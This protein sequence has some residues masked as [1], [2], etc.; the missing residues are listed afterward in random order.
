[1]SKRMKNV[2]ILNQLLKSELIDC[3][4]LKQT[5]RY[6]LVNKF[7]VF[8]LS[9]HWIL[10]LIHTCYILKKEISNLYFLCFYGVYS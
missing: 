1:M 5:H 7:Y 10:N 2:N 8:N 6:F 3:R 4:A 9:L